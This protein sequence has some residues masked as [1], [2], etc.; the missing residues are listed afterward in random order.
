METVSVTVD[1]LILLFF[2][3]CGA[4][5]VDSIAGGG[6]LIA[7]PVILATGVPPQLALG[8][9]K[10][11]ASFGSFSAAYNFIQKGE[12]E[13]RKCGIGIL[14]TLI[15]AAVGSV[16]VQLISKELLRHAIPVMLLGVLAYTALSRGLGD[17]DRPQ[18]MP[19]QPFYILFGLLLG[20]YDGFFGP[21]TG[22]FW[23]AALVSLLGYN[24]TRASGYTRVMNF[25][26]NIVAF[27]LFALGGN[28]LY[29]VGVSMAVGQFIGA[30]IGS[31]LAIRKGA[32]FIRP[33]FMA[34]VF[35]TILRLAYTNYA[36]AF[37][38]A[39]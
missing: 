12:V 32:R 1:L 31:G 8:T 26:S 13:I 16:A 37:F 34:V 35:V 5:F 23:T 10:F 4:G 30:R 19:T 7:L 38:L 9:N 18:R 15:G 24:L 17:Q 6:G 21:G 3:G 36:K 33:V 14:F 39:L 29:S 11:Q 2:T 20:G 27:A 28:V 25:T 22:S